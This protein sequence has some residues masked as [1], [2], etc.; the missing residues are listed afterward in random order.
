M[1]ETE[2]E[3][4]GFRKISFLPEEEYPLNQELLD[5]SF[6][7][8]GHSFPMTPFSALYKPSTYLNKEEW[9]DFISRKELTDHCQEVLIFYIDWWLK[10]NE[11]KKNDLDKVMEETGV[12]DA[13]MGITNDERLFFDSVFRIIFFSL[14]FLT[15]KGV[16]MDYIK[17]IVLTRPWGASFFDALDLW[18]QRKAAYNLFLND[19]P[20]FFLSHRDEI[21]P[22]L[23]DYLVLKFNLP[24]FPPT[25]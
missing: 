5:S 12:L 11:L 18:L 21:R 3:H 16:G 9:L 13:I 7:I 8:A 19:G 22:A 14:V 15:K 17:E 23:L 6:D 4:R 24:P 10:G 20:A 25:S 2:K 1:R